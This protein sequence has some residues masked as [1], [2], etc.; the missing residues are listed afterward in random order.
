[1]AGAAGVMVHAPSGRIAGRISF[2]ASVEEIYDVAVLP[3]LAR[4]GIVGPGQDVLA[5]AIPTTAGG[6]WTRE[7][8]PDSA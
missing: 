1:M 3:E 2:E 7:A 8:R 5:R 4:P 6:S